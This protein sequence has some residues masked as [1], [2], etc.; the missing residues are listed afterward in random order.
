MT[1]SEG[2]KSNWCDGWLT[3]CRLTFAV[4][5]L[6]DKP[7]KEGAAVVAEGG[8]LVVVH[9]EL[10]GDVYTETLVGRLEGTKCGEKQRSR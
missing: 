7:P 4:E 8:N 5:A 1:H 2:Q 6:S 9:A 3:E 10:V